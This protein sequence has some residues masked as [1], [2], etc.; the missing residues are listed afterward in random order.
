MLLTLVERVEAKTFFDEAVEDGELAEG[1]D[2][3]QGGGVG[4]D[5]AADEVGV[6]GAVAEFE[7]D[8]VEVLGSVRVE[9]LAGAGVDLQS[10]VDGSLQTRFRL[11]LG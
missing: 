7:D 9:E 6:F 1:C 8:E 10:R 2:V 4:G 5:F 3:V 11:W